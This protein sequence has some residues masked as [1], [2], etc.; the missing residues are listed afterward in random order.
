MPWTCAVAAK[1]KVAM[2]ATRLL[3]RCYITAVQN[4]SSCPFISGEKM[5]ALCFL[6]SSRTAAISASGSTAADVDGP[7]KAAWASGMDAL[8]SSSAMSGSASACGFARLLRGGM[9]QL[10]YYIRVYCLAPLLKKVV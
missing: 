7:I 6:Q 1:H 9:A 8:S 4:S 10:K 3:Q 5:D 2:K